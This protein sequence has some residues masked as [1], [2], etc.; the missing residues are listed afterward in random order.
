M[1]IKGVVNKSV[2]KH[3]FCDS[4]DDMASNFIPKGSNI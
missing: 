3:V 1:I 4:T 2:G